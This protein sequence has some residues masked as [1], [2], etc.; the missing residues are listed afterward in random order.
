MARCGRSGATSPP[1]VWPRYLLASL[2]VILAAALVGRLLPPAALARAWFVLGGVAA[3]L[4]ASV[5]FA[6]RAL[7]S[8]PTRTLRARD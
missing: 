6:L 3:T 7:A 2:A 1:T 5:G 8:R 4:L